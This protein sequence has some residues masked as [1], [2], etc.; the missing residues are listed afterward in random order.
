M[1]NVLI[2][3]AGRRVSLVKLF[4]KTL[5]EMFGNSAKVFTTDLFPELSSAAYQANGSFKVGKFTD[6]DYMDVLLKI[7]LNN[8]I[9][10]VI[11]TIDTELVLMAEH[12]NK[13]HENGIEIIVSD[14]EFVKIC[15]DKRKTNNFFS[16]NGFLT[17][18]EID[19]NYPKYPIFIK[20]ISG[21][22][23]KDLHL[24][25][26]PEELTKSLINNEKYMYLE[27]LSPSLFDEYT[28]DIYYNKQ[29]E[30][31]CVVPRLR[32]E[33]RAGEIS[34]GLTQKNHLMDF[35]KQ[36]LASI[37]G[38]QG[39]ITLQLFSNKKTQE[40]YGIEINP[41]FGGGYPISYH[42]GA[43]YPELLIKE[44]LLGTNTKYF[45]SWESNILSLRF[46]EELIVKNYGLKS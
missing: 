2:T 19:V 16:E 42:A 21:S 23:S 34:K 8:K 24:I 41:R 32:I 35:V 14:L 38:V 12:K 25:Q 33:T 15:R 7:C 3:S 44:Y 45:E 43:N 30:L 9:Q 10:L 37:K 27:Y 18:T 28:L 4:Q 29:S 1:A 20:P 6:A 40:V 11:P 22:N 46:D 5:Y 26:K 13:F 17:P 31:C 36:N 39:C